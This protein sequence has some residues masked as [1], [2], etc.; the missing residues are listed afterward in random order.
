MSKRI[1]TI[2][3]SLAAVC[4][5]ASAQWKQGDVPP[6]SRRGSIAPT[7]IDK[8]EVTV[9][10]AFNAENIKD[11]NTYID[12]GW[13]Q[14]GKQYTKY[15]SYFVAHSDSTYK[16]VLI[17]NSNGERNLRVSFFMGSQSEPIVFKKKKRKLSQVANNVDHST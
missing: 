7:E 1:I 9:Y 2:I 13:L 6:S 16:P 4:G 15:A 14:V 3:L 17:K 12:L 11:E 8:A 5:G 10:Y